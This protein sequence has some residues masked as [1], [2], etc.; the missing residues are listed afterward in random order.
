[1]CK[2][3]GGCL[4]WELLPFLFPS[5]YDENLFHYTGWIFQAQGLYSRNPCFKLLQAFSISHDDL[6]ISIVSGFHYWPICLVL[7]CNGFESDH[8][9]NHRK[10]H[11]G[12][13]HCTC[14]Q[15]FCQSSF[16]LVLCLTS[17]WGSPR[18]LFMASTWWRKDEKERLRL[19]CPNLLWLV[20]LLMS[21]M[22]ERLQMNASKI[23]Q[24]AGIS[25]SEAV[26]WT[27]KAYLTTSLPVQSNGNL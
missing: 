20:G 14:C 25:S 6:G 16:E 19:I 24:I 18:L 9:V 10:M 7:Q 2:D 8:R 3:I 15:I 1:M 22:E 26:F 11:W 23:M 21:H 17:P 4:S 12:L 13:F 5:A 27:T